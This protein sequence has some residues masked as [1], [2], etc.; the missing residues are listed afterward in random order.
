MAVNV[1]KEKTNLKLQGIANQTQESAKKL[2]QA[3]KEEVKA[4]DDVVMQVRAVKKQ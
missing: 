3:V 2:D 1:T 4:K